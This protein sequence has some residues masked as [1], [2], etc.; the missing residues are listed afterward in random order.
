MTA[1]LALD[2]LALRVPEPARAAAWLRDAFGL[3]DVSEPR[4]DEHRMVCRPADEVSAP[5]QE[6][7]LLRAAETAVDH[8]A[9]AV[10]DERHLDTLAAELGDEARRDDEGS[11]WFTDPIG[12]RVE[13]RMPSPRRERPAGAAPFDVVRLGHVTLTAPN[14]REAADFYCARLGM[15]VSER[16]GDSFIWLRCNR[17]HHV[18]AFAAG[19]PGL[20]HVGWEVRSWR[21]LRRACDHVPTTGI[22]IE[23]GPGRH[24]AG[25]NIFAY[26]LDPFGVRSELFCELRRIDDEAGYEAP[27][28]GDDA[29]K[30]GITNTWGPPPPETFTTSKSPC[31]GLHGVDR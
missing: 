19:A 27:D 11:L 8:L 2:H 28:W 5:A 15:R 21:E 18:I 6:L 30:L 25:D 1:V 4:P 22:R 31:C 20:H 9:F 24:G 3:A 14:P 17:D 12:L 7:T 13:L 26:L 23:Y 16:Y 29:R 10:A